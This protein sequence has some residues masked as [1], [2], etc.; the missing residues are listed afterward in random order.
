MLTKFA[1]NT[2]VR[3]FNKSKILQNTKIQIE[4]SIIKCN[5]NHKKCSKE[6][7]EN[8]FDAHKVQIG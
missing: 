7:S 5:R 6:Q 1:K 4:T 3:K 8:W 2:N